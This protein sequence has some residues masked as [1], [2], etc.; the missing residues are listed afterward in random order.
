MLY[1]YKNGCIVGMK[2]EELSREVL[3]KIIISFY[4]QEKNWT[5][6][7]LANKIE[8]NHS[9]IS[10]WMSGKNIST[11]NFKSLV[12]FLES[13]IKGEKQKEHFC[14]YLLAALQKE[15]YDIAK[16]SSII[17]TPGSL[18]SK[19]TGLLDVYSTVSPKLQ[20]ILDVY[21]IISR[22]KK[23]CY[24]YD[25]YFGVSQREIKVNEKNPLIRNHGVL[26]LIQQRNYIVLNFP[27]NYGVA[28][29]FTNTSF[30]NLVE[31]GDFVKQI[32]EKNNINLIIVITDNEVPFETQKFF[33]ENYNLFFE[34]ITNR[35]LEKTKISN[36]NI[37]YLKDLTKSITIYSYAQTA[38]DRFTS[39]FSVIKNEIIFKSYEDERKNITRLE[40]VQDNNKIKLFVDKILLKDIFNYSYLS[41]H[42]IYFER[43]RLY[44]EFQEMIEKDENN[45]LNLVVEM[46][47]PNAFLSSGIADKSKKIML[48]TSSYHSLDVINK[49]NKENDKGILADNIQLELAHIHPKYV[50][51]I[52]G[53]DIVGKVDLIILGFGM[54]S[55]ILNIT[56]YLRYVNS[57]LSPRGR[58][59]ISFIN[60]DSVLFQKQFD[61]YDRV[62]VSPLFFSDFAKHTIQENVD[63][64]IKLKRY[65][66]EEA[67]TL[68]ST[69]VDSYK[70]YT[71]PF[72]SGLILNTEGEKYLADEVRE[73]DKRYALSDECKHGHYITIIG[74]KEKLSQLAVGDTEVREKVIRR[75]IYD[76]LNFNKID[77]EVIT[78]AVS[79]DTKSLLINLLE[80]GEDMNEF[81]LLKTIF[82]QHKNERQKINFFKCVITLGENDISYDTKLR[83]V[84]EK[85]ITHMFGQGSVSPLVI[86]TSEE[87]EQEFSGEYLGI[88]LEQLNK[89]YVIFSSGI[90]SESIKMRRE[91]FISILREMGV[92]FFEQG[93]A[94]EC[95]N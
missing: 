92:R 68:V 1:L 73:I 65:T 60:A 83:L 46:C 63:L 82:F 32:K 71:Y 62:E 25:K 13:D 10:N 36:A 87:K 42:T 35:D 24:S 50:A 72:L 29:I 49:L 81:D 91:S 69:Y 47:C 67:K 90:N 41:R 19:I 74:N 93:S 56:E 26:N 3:A 57:W 27:H 94:V 44:E 22:L 78:H 16:C 84:S 14:Q 48:F 20:S 38:F 64:L 37:Y 85:R 12:A 95:E 17:D 28:L 88:G 21:S 45:P 2:M 15:N 55:S 59:F 52:Y 66:L 61:M 77:F 33:L 58:I 8:V 79:V 30:N 40:S 34:T 7:K 75:K 18:S 6:T 31:Y 43:N 76:Y 80:K 70:Y 9:S 53:D 5:Q 4:Y 11:K 89:E 51:N 54:G 86:L 39:Y 23:I